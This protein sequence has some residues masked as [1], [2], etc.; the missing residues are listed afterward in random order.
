MSRHKKHHNFK[1]PGLL[2]SYADSRNITFHQYSEYHMRL[3][4]GF[5]VIDIWTSGRYYVLSTNYAEMTDKS[6][7]ER[8]GEK[9]EL[10]DDTYTFLDNLFYA[11]DMLEE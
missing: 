11:P 8:G 2:E 4:D 10:N 6:I 5:T 9:D 1:L 7:V 3:M